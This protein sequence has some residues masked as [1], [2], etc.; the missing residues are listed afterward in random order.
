VFPSLGIARDLPLGTT[1]IIE[2]PAQPAGELRFTCGM[3]MYKGAL[4]IH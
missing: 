4:V 3:G 2:L 1:T